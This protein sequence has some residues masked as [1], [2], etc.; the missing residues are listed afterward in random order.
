VK[1]LLRDA[2]HV[3][4]Q[5]RNIQLQDW[6]KFPVEDDPKFVEEFQNIVNNP[7]IPEEDS[8]FT[9]DSFNDTYLNM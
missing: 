8:N 1:D 3:I 2:N 4:P 5:D 9:P 6:N 7:E